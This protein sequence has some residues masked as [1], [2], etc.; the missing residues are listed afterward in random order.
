LN[1]FAPP[2]QLNRYAPNLI[3][4]L[5]LI[6][7]FVKAHFKSALEL[8]ALILGLV[9][10]LWLLKFNRRDK[11]KLQVDP[12]HPEIYQWWFGLPERDFH[13]H[14]TRAFGFIAYVGI[15]N[16]GLRQ[17][18]LESWR[19]FIDGN[20]T[21][22]VELKAYNLPE[23]TMQIGT[24]LKMFP[25]LGQ[26]TLNFQGDT[27]VEPGTSISGMVYYIYECWGDSG[28]DPAIVNGTISGTFV[29]TDA[30]QKKTSCRIVFS[31][32]SLDEIKKLAE[33]IEHIR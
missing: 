6:F 26:R 29:I 28:W 23:L 8:S 9:N 14:P 5:E 1:E 15:V 27:L 25:N 21:K 31:E 3:M 13:G 11:P 24:H 33:G 7:Q 2:R 19:L 22:R 32:R 16:R 20:K 4:S 12:I 30:F 10:G 17:V 18:A